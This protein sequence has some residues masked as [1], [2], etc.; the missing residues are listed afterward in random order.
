MK[1]K[2]ISLAMLLNVPVSYQ[3]IA[4]QITQFCIVVRL[5]WR[6]IIIYDSIFQVFW[7]LSR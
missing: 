1:H 3:L 7:Y 5:S 4:S 6:R 2:L